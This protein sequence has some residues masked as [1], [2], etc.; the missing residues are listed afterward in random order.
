[1][2]LQWL[3][4]NRR[5]VPDGAEALCGISARAAW[6][7]PHGQWRVQESQAAEPSASVFGEAWCCLLGT[8]GRS[9]NALKTR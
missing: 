7:A 9:A 6:A 5:A 2:K 4:T 3:R 8:S 1:M